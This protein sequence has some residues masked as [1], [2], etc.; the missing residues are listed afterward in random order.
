MRLRFGG[1]EVLLLASLPLLSLPLR[2]DQ[3]RIGLNP[4]E[5]SQSGHFWI[6]NEAAG[7]DSLL[8]LSKHLATHASKAHLKAL[9]QEQRAPNIAI[10]NPRGGS[11]SVLD[12]DAL[13]VH[14]GAV[15]AA[16]IADDESPA[17]KDRNRD[18]DI[19]YM[20]CRDLILR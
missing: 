18:R 11:G 2:D 20:T 13:A 5:L 15:L 4:L 10:A 17:K 1:Q 8:P 19:C 14:E 3:A 12:P 7:Q 16:Q 9:L 6:G